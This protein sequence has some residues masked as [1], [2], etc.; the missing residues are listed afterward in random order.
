MTWR[1]VIWGGV[2][3]WIHVTLQ[4]I[5]EGI[6]KL[7]VAE[8]YSRKSKF[9]MNTLKPHSLADLRG[10][11]ER[12]TG[13]NSI[14]SMQFFGKFDKILSWHLPPESWRPHLRKILDPPLTLL[15]QTKE[16]VIIFFAILKDLEQYIWTYSAFGER[17]KF[18]STLHNNCLWE[19]LFSIINTKSIQ[20]S[21]IM[22]VIVQLW[23]SEQILRMLGKFQCYSDVLNI[24]YNKGC[25]P[26]F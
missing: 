15:K 23:I 21:C 11:E 9:W 6:L 19:I 5:T 2:T 13:P 24:K 10:L 18:W 3:F 16:F 8:N 12:P 14:N 20:W 1:K 4:N 22:C 25:L 7:F 26:M 17:R